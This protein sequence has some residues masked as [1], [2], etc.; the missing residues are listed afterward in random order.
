[1]SKVLPI[2]GI[3]PSSLFLLNCNPRPQPNESPPLGLGVGLA[4]TPTRMF[5]M[6]PGSAEYQ[7]SPA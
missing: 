5:F 3:L 1:M 6:N 4:V 7:G 2:L